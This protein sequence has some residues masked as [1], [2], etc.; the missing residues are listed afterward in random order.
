MGA[1]E[2]M[3]CGAEPA[4]RSGT[5]RSGPEKLVSDHRPHAVVPQTHGEWRE[6]KESAAQ[7]PMNGSP[8]KLCGAA[9]KTRTSTAF[10]PQRPQ[11]CASTNSAMAAHQGN[12]APEHFVGRMGRVAGEGLWCKPSPM[13]PAPAS[14]NYICAVRSWRW[15][16]GALRPGRRRGAGCAG[17]HSRWPGHNPG[18]RRRRREPGWRDRGSGSSCWAPPP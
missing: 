17:R 2:A 18:T 3:A 14:L 6:F 8:A 5:P 9:K 4:G 13:P 15:L 7:V 12:E 10:R 1:G 16:R 11:R